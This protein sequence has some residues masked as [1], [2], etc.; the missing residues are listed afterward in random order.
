MS[1]VVTPIPRLIDLTAPAFTLGTANAAGAALTAIASNS[2]LL[3]YDT[4]VPTTIASAASAATGEAAT[5]ARRDHTHGMYTATAQ[6]V[7][8]AVEAETDQDTYIPPDLIKYSPG[9]AKA[10]AQINQTGTQ[11][12]DGS[13]NVSGITDNAAGNTTITFS[14]NFSADTYSQVTNASGTLYASSGA[15]NG[16]RVNDTGILVEALNGTNTDTGELSWAGFGDQ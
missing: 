5:S 15:G 10:W 2:T 13:Y 12:L 6:A 1:I 3:V 14:T 16:T 8:S 7:Q 4:S 11:S 9:V